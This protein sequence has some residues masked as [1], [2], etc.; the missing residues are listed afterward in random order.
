MQESCKIMIGII[1][2]YTSPANKVYIGQTTDEKRRRKTFL[3]LS[4]SYGGVKIDRARLK[5]KP[6]NFKYEILYKANFKSAKEAQQKLDEMEQFY[7]KQCNSYRAGYNMTYGGYTT[8]GFTFS[9][10]QKK[11]MSESRKGRK[12]RPRTE[13]EKLFQSLIMKEKW[14]SERYRKLRE[15]ISQSEEHR[16]KRSESVSGSKN[17]MYGRSHTEASK[18]KMSQSRF[19]EKN[20]WYGKVKSED[21]R[22]KICQSMRDYYN[23]HRVSTETKE[24]IAKSISIPVQQFSKSGELISTYDSATIAGNLVGVDSSC[25]IKVCKGKR[26][27]AGGYIWK[28]A[29]QQASTVQWEDAVQS[30]DW[31]GIAEI[32]T[33]TCR[34]RNVIYYHIKKHGVP[35]VLNGRMR[36]IYLPA[37]EKILK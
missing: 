11:R 24:R 26:K 25:I 36:L 12:T 3:K 31:L 8:T 4:K 6:E 10:E 9:D 34:D 18:E 27:S 22:A 30:N 17:G 15:Q 19:G 23:T 28:Y 7:I 35:I 37:L 29:N 32:V 5:H 33:R 13:E 2:K 16:R 20:I 21:Y 14:A 1:Y